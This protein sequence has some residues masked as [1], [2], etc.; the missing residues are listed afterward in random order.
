MDAESRGL[1]FWE[2]CQ[3]LVAGMEGFTE[4]ME[5]WLVSLIVIAKQGMADERNV[6]R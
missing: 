6:M 5:V 3:D 2:D 4:T 1:C